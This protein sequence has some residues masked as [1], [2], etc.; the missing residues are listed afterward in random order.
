MGESV[1]V[2]RLI[3]RI[4]PSATVGTSWA[5]TPLARTLDAAYAGPGSAGTSIGCRRIW[6]SIRKPCGLLASDKGPYLR[7]RPYTF[8][9]MALVQEAMKVLLAK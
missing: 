2:I 3:A 1:G 6:A 4:A 9:I 7:V 8:I 5:S